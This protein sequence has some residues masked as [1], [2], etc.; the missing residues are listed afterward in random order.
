MRLKQLV[1]G[2]FRFQWQYGIML[3]ALIM[4]LVWSAIVYLLP[5]STM[6]IALPILLITDFA[7]AGFLLVSAMLFFEKGQRTLQA[8]VVTPIKVSEYLLAKVIAMTFTL[9]TI[10]VVLGVMIKLMKQVPLNV[11]LV[12]V[13][14]FFSCSFFVLLGIVISMFYQSFTD[15]ILPMGVVFSV[16][17]I[18]FL[19]Y[20]DT[21][22][23]DYLDK[24]VWVFPTYAMMQLVAW[25]QGQ[26]SLSTA[27][28]AMAYLILLGWGLFILGIRLFNQKMIGREG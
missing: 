11:S 3:A 17:F 14:A 27:L 25:A 12:F 16:M 8:L 28:I 7:V 10:A 21:P 13:A 6:G 5:S 19:V 20:V 22:A 2:D 1:L 15:L 26:V 23:F 24:V 4:T 18:P 9:S